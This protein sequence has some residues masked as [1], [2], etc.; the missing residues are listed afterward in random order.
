MQSVSTLQV[1]LTP[2][3]MMFGC[4]NISIWTYLWNIGLSILSKLAAKFVF[5]ALYWLGVLTSNWL[6][7]LENM[8]KIMA[9]QDSQVFQNYLFFFVLL[10]EKNKIY[11]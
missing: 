2:P 10:I 11:G 9:L 5:Q 3:M 4:P 1:H 6:L 7:K 8:V